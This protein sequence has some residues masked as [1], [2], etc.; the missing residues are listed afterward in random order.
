[1]ELVLQGAAIKLFAKAVFS[2]SKVGTSAPR[3]PAW[4]R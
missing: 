1:M 4:L 2:L 3:A